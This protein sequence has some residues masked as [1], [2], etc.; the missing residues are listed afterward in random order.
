MGKKTRIAIDH[1]ICSGGSKIDPR[2]CCKCLQIC[3][4]AV[5]LLHQTLGA[6]EEDPYDPR[7]W[8]ITPLWLSLCTRCMKC[9]EVCPEGAVS[10]SW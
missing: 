7:L 10:V 5:F 3:E 9:V 6:E 1:S 2:D 4:P 8:S